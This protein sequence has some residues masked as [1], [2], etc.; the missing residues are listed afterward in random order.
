MR[1]AHPNHPKSWTLL[2]V[3]SLEAAHHVGTVRGNAG[4]R[5]SKTYGLPNPLVSLPNPVVGLDVGEWTRFKKKQKQKET[6]GSD[7]L[8]GPTTPTDRNLPD[9]QHLA[10]H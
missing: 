3:F 2:P 4:F 6:G 10:T 5:L 7:N 8:F 1:T 9:Q